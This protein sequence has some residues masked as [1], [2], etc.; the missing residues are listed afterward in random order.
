[1]S[2]SNETASVLAYEGRLAD[3]SEYLQAHPDNLNRP[4]ND[5][6]TPLHWAC[7][8]GKAD[9]VTF[10]LHEGANVNSEDDTNWTPIL[11]R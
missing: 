1:M 8:S 3:L 10:L 5:G 9:I 6:R 7:S 4:D 11:I 2:V